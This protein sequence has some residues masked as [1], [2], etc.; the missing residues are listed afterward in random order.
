MALI[1]VSVWGSTVVVSKGLLLSLSPVQ[2]MFLRFVFAYGAMWFICPKWFFRWREEWRFL[3]LALFSNTLYYLAENTALTMTQTTNVSILVSTAPIFTAVILACLHK[4]ERL[5]RRQILGFGVAFSGVILVVFNGDGA[6]KLN[7]LGDLLALGAAVSWA[8]YGI[9][10]RRWSDQYDTALITRKLMFYG[11]LTTLPLVLAE[12]APVDPAAVFTLKNVVKLLYLSLIGNAAC[13]LLWGNAVKTIGVLSANL[14][15]YMVPIVTL[16]V[17]AV[18]L[19]ESVSA[20]GL[21][22]IALVILGMILGTLSEKD[23]R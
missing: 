5:T 7:F 23:T 17:S 18:V 3:V 19:G 1:C 20:S 15:I 11:T 13:Y 10:L 2:L 22:G 21:V 9:L 6:L 8:V 14:Y 16:L 12:V 4:E